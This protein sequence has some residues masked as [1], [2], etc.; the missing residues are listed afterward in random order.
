MESKAFSDD[1]PKILKGA[2]QRGVFPLPLPSCPDPASFVG[3]V[4]GRRRQLSRG[5]VNSW[6]LGPGYGGL[7]EQH[8]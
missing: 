6:V 3:S 7:A 8:V 2:R 1:S 4:K 5:H